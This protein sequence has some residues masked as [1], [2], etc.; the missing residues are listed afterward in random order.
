MFNIGIDIDGTLSKYP[1]FL[2]WLGNKIVE[3]GGKVYIITGLGKQ[4]AQ[5]RFEKYCKI[6]TAI[7]IDTSEYNSDERKLIG[8]VESNEEIVG[9][10]KQRKCK[11]LE[12]DFMFDDKA[13]VH[14]KFGKI[15]IFEVK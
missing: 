12:I 2:N 15:P 5:L 4:E 11:E 13:S 1:E 9:K 7:L 10:F 6:P 14:R 8:Q 3:S